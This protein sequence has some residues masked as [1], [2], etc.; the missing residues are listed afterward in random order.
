MRATCPANL[1]LLDF[2]TRIGMAPNFKIIFI[3]TIAFSW[4]TTL[5]IIID[6]HHAACSHILRGTVFVVNVATRF[7]LTDPR[8]SLPYRG[9]GHPVL[10]GALAPC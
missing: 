7:I 9:D 4:T 5:C 2:I 1:I 6:R 3:L 8:L 10:S